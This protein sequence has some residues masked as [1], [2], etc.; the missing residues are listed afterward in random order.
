MRVK[1]IPAALTL[2]H[3]TQKTIEI[4][5]TPGAGKSSVVEQWAADRSVKTGRP[6]GLFIFMLATIS[7]YDF[8]GFMYPAQDPDDPSGQ[9]ISAFSR[10]PVIPHPSHFRNMRGTSF[11]VFVDGEKVDDYD[12]VPD[13]GAVFLDEYGQADIDMKK[14]SA[15]LMLN[16]RVRGAAMPEGWGVIAAS[17]R[18]EDR[19]GV[20]K[21]LSFVLN[22]ITRI[23]MTNSIDDFKAYAV[24]VGAHYL[25]TAW[26]SFA[27]DKVF[28]QMAPE[29]GQQFC[30]PRSLMSVSDYIHALE[31]QHG[32]VDWE[33]DFVREMII[34]TIGHGAGTEVVAFAEMASQLATFEEIVKDPQG[35]PM[36]EPKRADALHAVC[37]MV[38]SRVDVKTAVPA[39]NY[40]LRAP[41]EFQVATLLNAVQRV[42]Q[43][44]VTPKFRPWLEK[45]Q[46]LIIAANIKV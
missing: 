2:A 1:N 30:S 29:A 41:R 32:K 35:A 31:R 46:H 39:F 3:E 13:Q 16:R 10:P 24:V 42:P 37:D 20:T 9:R 34:G 40:I 26:A 23:D 8:G 15:D 28:S 12:G 25:I 43:L 7:P 36:P 27:P 19:S 21:D 4:R 5:S 17:N 44:T 11:M 22:R 33:S 18:Q 14:M 38:V 45:N 6:F